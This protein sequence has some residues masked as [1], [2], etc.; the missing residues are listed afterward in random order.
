MYDEKQ[1]NFKFKQCNNIRIDKYKNC[2]TN[3]IQIFG[4][5]I[6]RIFI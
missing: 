4:F 1:T 3:M 2:I 5:E 6:I